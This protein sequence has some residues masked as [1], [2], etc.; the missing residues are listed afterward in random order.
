MPIS[1]R[2]PTPALSP[3]TAHPC[4]VKREI[5]PAAST[6]NRYGRKSVGSFGRVT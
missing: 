5:R 3:I 2:E 1:A 4:P 6:A